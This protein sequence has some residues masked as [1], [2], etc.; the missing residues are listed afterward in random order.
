MSAVIVSGALATKAR[1]GGNAWSRLGWV[2]G[3]AALGFDCWFVEQL[4]IGPVVPASVGWFQ[5]VASAHGLRGRAVLID[6][7]DLLLAGP[8]LELD[9]L[10][11]DAALVLNISGH[12]PARLLV[13]R[14]GPLLFLDDDPGFTQ[15]WELEGGCGSRLEG[16]DLFLTYGTNIGADLCPIPTVGRSWLPIVPPVAMTDWPEVPVPDPPRITTVGTW[17]GPFGPVSFNG[18]TNG[19]KLHEFRKVIELPRHVPVSF[20]MALDIHAEETSDLELLARNGW[21]L[22]DPHGVVSTPD[23]Y[24]RWIQDSTA[25]FSAAQG[26]YVGTNSGWVSDRTA[27]YLASGRPAVVQDTGLG[28]TIPVGDGLLTYHDLDDAVA[29]VHEVLGNYEH[30][31]AAARK[32][33]H[34]TFDA[35]VVARRVCDLAGVPH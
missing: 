4:P 31:A 24:R 2:A 28:R 3:F 13:D 20:E 23:G 34:E 9:R 33:A 27:C 22:D 32:L 7:D 6:G 16:H 25:E 15:A 17:R 29:A 8:D 19:V 21:R 5:A 10:V 11:G 18:I 26:T 12:L 1:N 35:T 14:S 30:H